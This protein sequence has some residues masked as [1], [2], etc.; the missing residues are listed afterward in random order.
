MQ[1]GNRKLIIT[2]VTII[3]YSA[4]MII[5]IKT[6][7]ALDPFALGAGL[8][9]LLAPV[10]YGYGKEYVSGNGSGN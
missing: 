5:S 10:M 3:S 2:L 4:M 8:G 6:G 9:G 1:R 7:N